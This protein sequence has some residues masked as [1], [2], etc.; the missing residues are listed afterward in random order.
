MYHNV[1]NL[2]THWYFVQAGPLDARAKTLPLPD[3]LMGELVAYVVTHEVGHT[4]GLPHNMKASSLYPFDKLR[5]QAVAAGQR[6]H[7]DDHGLLA[8]QLRGA[9]GGRHPRRR[10]RAA[11]RSLRRLR[12]QVGLSADRGLDVGGRREDD[13]RR[14]GAPAGSDALAALLDRQQREAPIPASSPKRSATPTP[15]PRRRWA[16]RTSSASSAMLLAATSKPDEP[17]DDLE[18]AYAPAP[19]PVGPRDEPRL[20]DRR[21]PRLAAEAPAARPAWCSRRSRRPANRRRSQFLNANAFATPV[22]LVRP[23]ILRRIEPAGALD[24]LRTAQQRVLGS[25]LSSPRVLRLVE[26]Q[27][28]DGAAA[29]APTDFLAEVRTGVWSEFAGTREL[30]VDAFRRNLQRAYLDTLAERVNGRQAASDDARA[31]FRQEL[32]LVDN[33]ITGGVGARGGRLDAR[34]RHRRA[35][36]DRTGARSDGAG[37]GPG[38]RPAHDGGQLAGSP[39]WTTLRST[40]LT[41]RAAGPTTRSACRGTDAGATGTTAATS[42]YAGLRAVAL[43]GFGAAARLRPCRFPGGTSCRSPISSRTPGTRCACSGA[44]PASP[45]PRWPRWR[46]A[47]A[48]TPP[49]SRWS[50]R[51]C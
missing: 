11:H 51:C 29:Y 39:A 16:S 30:R 50:T 14:V 8:L 36:P 37:D 21:R 9:A 10:P 15:S 41:R 24:R 2:L 3:A 4:L 1:M 45:S 13:P 23:E 12:D 47:S 46:S 44:A 7:A 25:L 49:S 31:L 28:L 38:R 43:S 19:R 22:F 34:A 18:Q 5:D 48:P 42:E 32:R 40:R 27:A 20:G 26:E 6:P 17:Y 35:R 33:L